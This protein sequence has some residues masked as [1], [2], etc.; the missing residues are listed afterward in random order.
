MKRS[1][2]LTALIVFAA[3]SAVASTTPRAPADLVFAK[4]GGLAAV[5]FSRK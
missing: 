4:S 2:P 3:S 1:P 5:V